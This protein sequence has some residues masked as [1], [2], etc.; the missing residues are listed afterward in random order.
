MASE[1]HEPKNASPN[2][3]LDLGRLPL[4]GRGGHLLACRTISAPSSSFVGK[5]TNFRGGTKRFPPDSNPGNAGLPKHPT[6]VSRRRPS[7]GFARRPG[8]CAGVRAAPQKQGVRLMDQGS[9]EVVLENAQ[10]P[11]TG[12]P[13]AP[14]SAADIQ[15]R[16]RRTRSA[17][18]K[19]SRPLCGPLP[20]AEPRNA[21]IKTMVER[22]SRLLAFAFGR[23]A[24]HGARG[25]G[26]EA[27]YRRS[28]NRRTEVRQVKVSLDP[29]FVDGECKFPQ[30]RTGTP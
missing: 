9:M 5:Q 24:F 8:S 1:S 28:W 13:S 25:R 26:A 15:T 27:F 3:S 23:R 29:K 14:A 16:K 20:S 7:D 10:R 30:S 18:K 19:P 2:R 4:R 11:K 12:N 22:R 17:L 6:A 21:A